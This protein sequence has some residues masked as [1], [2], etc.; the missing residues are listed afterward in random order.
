LL[1]L[2][3]SWILAH[4]RISHNNRHSLREQVMIMLLPYLITTP[5]SARR[6]PFGEHVVGYTH[7]TALCS[8]SDIASP[9]LRTYS[10]GVQD[11]WGHRRRPARDLPSSHEYVDRRIRSWLV[12]RGTAEDAHPAVAHECQGLDGVLDWSEWVRCS[13]ECGPEVSASN[14]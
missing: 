4:S 11:L 6:R 10:S 13:P 2:T 9:S 7:R 12:E 3:T 5:S 14:L 1:C 8:Y